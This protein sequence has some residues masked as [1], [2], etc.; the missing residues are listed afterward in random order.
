MADPNAQQLGPVVRF[1]WRRVTPDGETVA[2]GLQILQLGSDGRIARDTQF[3]E[4]AGPPMSE[5]ALSK[6]LSTN[7]DTD[8]KEQT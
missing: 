8:A 6:R 4:P 1:N 3:L 7:L 2:V 5:E